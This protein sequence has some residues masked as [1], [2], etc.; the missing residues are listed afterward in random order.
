[1]N[2]TSEEMVSF[3]FPTDRHVVHSPCM[4]RQDN[5]DTPT[6]REAMEFWIV[7]TLLAAAVLTGAWGLM[8]WL[9]S[10]H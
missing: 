10:W 8:R 1:M 3:R 4:A 5:D 9:F 7:G 6:V 2:H